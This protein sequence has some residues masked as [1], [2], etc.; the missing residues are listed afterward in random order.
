MKIEPNGIIQIYNTVPLN[1]G[2]VNMS[3]KF[4][5]KVA[6]SEYF[7]SLPKVT[8]TGNTYVRS[9]KGIRVTGVDNNFIKSANYLRYQNKGFDDKWY[10]AF[11]TD[12]DYLNNNVYEL[13]IEEDV[14]QT[15]HDEMELSTC[16]VERETVD[17]DQIGKNVVP[18]NIP[19]DS[20]VVQMLEHNYVF[21][22]NTRIVIE[23][24]PSTALY[25]A[26]KIGNIPK[27]QPKIINNV[28]TGSSYATFLA[29]EYESVTEFIDACIGS[30]NEVTNVYLVPSDFYGED[31]K[32]QW[33]PDMQMPTSY[34]NYK[35]KNNKLFTY[36][37]TYVKVSGTDE[38]I[39]LFHKMRNNAIGF[40]QNSVTTPR[41]ECS[42]I[43][44]FY[45]GVENNYESMI[46]LNGFPTS[47]W[48]ESGVR[49]SD[50]LEK[51]L[52]S[53]NIERVEVPVAT[54]DNERQ[55]RNEKITEITTGRLQYHNDSRKGGN[56]TTNIAWANNYFGFKVYV[57][58]VT[59]TSAEIIDSYFTKYGYKVDKIK[60]IK[61]NRK[62]YDYVKTRGILVMGKL[63]Q[64]ARNKIAK[65]YNEGITMWYEPNSFGNYNVE[66]EVL[67]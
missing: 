12:V 58:G 51:M 36:P 40:T 17:N 25:I 28:Y 67:S 19:F 41:P 62:V 46:T 45:N 18:E 37:Y 65:M 66:N 50:V 30:G 49:V 27:V 57:Y 3:L 52:M 22:A 55:E 38:Q 44:L 13:S 33:L 2:T 24:T 1:S 35:P 7:N 14:L 53:S 60:E 64:Y 42:M 16:Y 59:E 43:P 32:S 48:L 26:G 31:E 8:I 29:S 4:D 20:I 15:W 34:G 10:Y 63:P 6:Q 61:R 21:N 5:D 9:I 23:Y 47:S 56:V 54:D 39:F 11:I